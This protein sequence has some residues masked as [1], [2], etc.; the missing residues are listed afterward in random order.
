MSQSVHSQLASLVFP[1][2]LLHGFAS[3]QKRSKAKQ[4]TLKAPS[5]EKGKV[6][7]TFMFIGWFSSFPPSLYL[8]FF[9]SFFFFFSCL[10]TKTTIVA[11]SMFSWLLNRERE[12]Q[13]NDEGTVLHDSR[14]RALSALLLTHLLRLF[15]RDGGENDIK[16]GF[17]QMLHFKKKS[18][19]E[20]RKESS[21]EEVLVC[22]C[23]LGE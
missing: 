8:S 14:P 4:N 6:T 21:W 9:L 13:G 17:Y 19:S 22:V 7:I 12:Y 16:R 3:R 23:V 10:E 5:C 1:P 2:S 20:S 11:K 18:E 15:L